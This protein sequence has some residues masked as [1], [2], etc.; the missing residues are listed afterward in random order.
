MDFFECV[1]VIVIVISIFDSLTD[2]FSRGHDPFTHVVR[3]R[4][5]TDVGEPFLSVSLSLSFFGGE[6]EMRSDAKSSR[7]RDFPSSASSLVRRGG[8]TCDISLDRN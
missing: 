6:V 3:V 4:S 1:I 5:L 7:P 8:P 2:S